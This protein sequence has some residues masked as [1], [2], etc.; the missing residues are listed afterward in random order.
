MKK[1][2]ILLFFGVFIAK[3]QA[4][5]Y[6]PN[7]ESIPNKNNYY[8]AF[9]NAKIYVTPTQIIEKGTLLIQNGKVVAS[10]NSV[11]IPKNAMIIDAEGKSIY[12]SFIDMYTSFG[13]DK[14]K[15]AASSER[16]SSYDTK[17][18]G[19]YWNENI[20]SEINAY[21]TFAYDETKAEELLKAGFG[22]VGTHIQDGI[23]RG[24][25]AIV[26][27]NNSDKTNR[28]LSNKASQ[29]FGFTRSVTTNQSYP[30]S[31]MGMMALLRQMYHDKEW[32]KNGNATNKDLSLEA[33]IAN[34]KLVQIFAAEDKLNSLRA[35]K[36]AKEFG[37]NYILKG[38]GNE[39]ERIQEIKKTNA[40]FIIPINF[41]EAYDVSN[42][43][44]ANQMELA[45]LR[46]W[47]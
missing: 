9:T 20:R 33:L 37:L 21:E 35:S 8:T 7:N 17:R 2:I 46:F 12:P 6:F 28:I 16:G 39:F 41:P 42:P 31:L 27:L 40:S 43:F 44:N 26:A 10:G 34:E 30:S 45:D 4:Q 5:E 13:A 14:P 36:I 3:T 22:V 11:A 24:T 38:A 47:N 19:Y 1:L 15:R 18:A 32:Y 23:A 25:G 29:H